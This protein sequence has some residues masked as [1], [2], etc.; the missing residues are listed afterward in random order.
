M[1]SPSAMSIIDV[2][3]HRKTFFVLKLCTSYD[4]SSLF[5]FSHVHYSLIFKILSYVGLLNVYKLKAYCC[6]SVFQ[7]LYKLG[8][9]DQ[10]C[11][12]FTF[13]TN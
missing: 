6:E 1:F 11:V 7:N 12:V 2:N 10:N 4:I 5:I 3:E 9:Y 8:F 13:S